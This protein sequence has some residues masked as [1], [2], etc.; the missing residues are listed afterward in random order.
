MEQKTDI[1]YPSAP[2]E[3]KN[4]NFEQRLEKKLNDVKSFE[5]SIITINTSKIKTTNPKRKIKK[6][7]NYN[8]QIIRY[9]CYYYH[10]IEVYH[11]LSYRNWF[12][13]Y[14]KINCNSMR[15]IKW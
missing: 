14:T 12:D 9:I 3:K 2:F 4:I 13:S 8:I 15:I 11:T 10:N 1:L 5:I 6:N 7:V